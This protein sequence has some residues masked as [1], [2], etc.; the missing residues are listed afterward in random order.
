MG[1][2]RDQAINLDRYTAAA[3]ALQSATKL[4][5]ELDAQQGTPA[6][7]LPDTSSGSPKHLRVGLDLRAADHGALVR[8]L[9]AQGVIT[10]ADYLAAVADGAEREAAAAGQLASQRLGKPVTFA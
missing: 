4:Q 7:A 5:L 3:H 2:P 10:E 6:P 8:L 9:I 1:D